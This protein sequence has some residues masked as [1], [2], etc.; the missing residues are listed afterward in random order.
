MSMPGDREPLKEGVFFSSNV[1][2]EL[3]GE[4]SVAIEE[5]IWPRGVNNLG[6]KEH[7]NKGD[8][9]LTHATAEVRDSK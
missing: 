6:A 8:S 1:F 2:C 3:D 4:V 7:A 5:G 9:K